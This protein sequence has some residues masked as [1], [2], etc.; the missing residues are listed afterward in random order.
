MLSCIFGL[1]EEK[2]HCLV[3]LA[4]LFS[5]IIFVY[6]KCLTRNKQTFVILLFSLLRTLL[7]LLKL[8]IYGAKTN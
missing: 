4:S 1:N 3:L 5:L 2:T 6:A 7:L 8:F